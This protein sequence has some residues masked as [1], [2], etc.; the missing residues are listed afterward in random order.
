MVV[1][2]RGT[3]DYADFTDSDRS[4]G[5]STQVVSAQALFTLLSMKHA[6]GEAEAERDVALR[7]SGLA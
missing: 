6:R 4:Q 1:G 2:L 7:L 3:T 5:G